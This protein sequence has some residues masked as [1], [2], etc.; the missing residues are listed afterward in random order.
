MPFISFLFLYGTLSKFCSYFEGD[1]S[2]W[3]YYLNILM[4]IE[5]HFDNNFL[6]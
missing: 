1:E 6:V 2:W 4:N 5:N 3:T